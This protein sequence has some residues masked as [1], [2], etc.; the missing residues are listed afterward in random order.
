MT[1]TDAQVR[2]QIAS[3]ISA[4]ASSAVV[5]PWWVLGVKQD[6]WPGMLRSSSDSN[7]VH[8][9]VFTRSA[10]QATE[11]SM[12]C[13]RHDWIYD[14]WA[15]HYYSTGTSASNSDFTFNAELDAISAAFDDVSSLHAAL[16]RRQPI[17]WRVDLQVYGGELMHFAVGQLRIEAC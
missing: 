14:L 3:V 4:A 6:M 5:F 2:A 8:A 1:Y 16:K 10:D 17:T 13:V 11:E 15:F 7:R 9:Y 12:R